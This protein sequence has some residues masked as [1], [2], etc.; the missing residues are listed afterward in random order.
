[1]TTI[2]VLAPLRIETRFRAPGSDGR[3][4]LQLRVYPDDFSMAHGNVEPN[5]EELDVLTSA[6]D[7]PVDD[8]ARFSM[9]AGAVGAP[10]AAWL[11]RHRPFGAAAPDP[12]WPVGATPFGLPPEL[13]VWIVPKNEPAYLADTLVLD[14][15]AIRR[16]MQPQVFGNGPADTWWQSFRRACEVHLGTEIVLGTTQPDLEC[17]V[18]VGAGDESPKALLDDHLANG[19]L[20][21]VPQGTPTNTVEGEQAAEL[22]R[23]I[24]YWYDLAAGTDPLL[25]TGAIYTALTG[26][27]A[28]TW[29]SPQFDAHR[30]PGWGFVNGLWPALWGRLFRDVL[31][32]GSLER[33]IWDWAA[34]NL[35]PQGPYPAI[36]VGNQPY[37]LLPVTE[38]DAWVEQAGDPAVE[39][40]LIQFARA[41]RDLAAQGAETGRTVVGAD[42]KQL[43]HLYGSHAPNRHWGVRPVKPRPLAAAAAAAFGYPPPDLSAWY[44]AATATLTGAN[45]RPLEA[46]WL[47]WELPGSPE[48]EYDDPRAVRELL[49]FAREGTKQLKGTFGLFGHLVRE[50]VVIMRCLVGRAFLLTLPG[51]AGGPD[52]PLTL[53]PPSTDP[54][55]H[56]LYAH[57]SPN[58]LNVLRS[59]GDPG[60][61]AVADRY[62]AW[63]ETL[64]H[65]IS[66]W[67]NDRDDAFRA[68]LATLDTASFRVDPWVTGVAERRLRT[69]SKA[70]ADFR[71]G[72]YGW[73]DDLRPWTGAPDDPLPPG[74]TSTGLVHTPG[75]AQAHTAAVLR[76]ASVRYPDESMWQL[77][78]DSAKV[79]GA[80]RLAER[81]RLGVHPY[82]AV[83]LEVERIAG[84]WETVRLLRKSFALVDG[85]GENR[86]TDGAAAL[87]AILRPSEPIDPVLAA[88]APKLTPL[89]EVLD[90]YADLLVADGVHALV[91]GQTQ[92]GNAAMEAAAGLGPPPELRCIRTPRASTDV[93]SAVW[94]LLDGV[95]AGDAVTDPRVVADPAFDAFIGKQTTGV[96]HGPTRDRIVARLS[97]LF[98][99]G[100]DNAPDAPPLASPM[101][102]DLS[103]RRARI[104]ALLDDFR[105]VLKTIGTATAATVALAKAE[106]AAWSIDVADDEGLKSWADAAE[107]ELRRRREQHG[108]A[109]DSVTALRVGIRGLVGDPSLPILPIIESADLLPLVDAPAGIDHE[110]LPIVAA[111]RP[112]VANLEAWQLDSTRAWAARIVDDGEP[113]EL[114]HPER[115]FTAV[116]DARTSASKV[117]VCPLDAWTDAIPSRR[118]ITAAAFGFNGPKSRAPHAVLLA[119]PPDVTRRATNEGLV[120][121]VLETRR[122]VRARVTS[123][124][125][126]A[127]VAPAA[128][129]LSSAPDIGFH[130]G[131]P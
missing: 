87:E 69:M 70:G 72:A 35:A 82:E 78:I 40:P 44:A 64:A 36:R 73:V 74:P 48:A 56:G 3:W 18:V 115:P 98:G 81:V 53:L 118:H 11:W 63:K 76:D 24:G 46:V 102:T 21:V 113:P 86:T 7:A 65:V 88:L 84:D 20:A 111:V 105:G 25:G 121:V 41:W 75:I 9:L 29:P 71:L 99:G 85:A 34:D 94:L 114:W 62:E 51:N 37:G 124:L 38:L 92:I 58:A 32:A 112:R 45:G 107:A 42:T 43:L 49:E 6:L 28:P 30:S 106:A 31:G 80:N 17:V 90:T 103:A 33:D 59:S 52:D 96:P 97:A 47:P 16:D 101:V 67:E 127:P 108:G 131:W 117:A 129:V 57:A 109:A 95:S 61:T 83:G 119:I 89:D 14:R 116:Y 39:A 13:E 122:T 120:K 77:N 19:R 93:H 125:D 10:R 79:R 66:L 27:P 100:D 1:M 60:L 110:W 23:D 12:P 5:A 26:T 22:G 128:P 15:A 91:S 68:L 55:L 8:K 4:R 123:P 104:I 50:S 2:E 126:G 54:H 130:E